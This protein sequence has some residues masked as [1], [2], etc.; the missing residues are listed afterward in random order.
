[1]GERPY[2]AV[3]PVCPCAAEPRWKKKEPLVESDNS[4]TREAQPPCVEPVSTP[5]EQQPPHDRRAPNTARGNLLDSSR[6][7]TT[8][9]QDNASEV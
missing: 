4:V 1:M 7:D 3:C 6:G 2:P 8:L 9:P 5:V